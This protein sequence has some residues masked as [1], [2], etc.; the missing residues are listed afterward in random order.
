MKPALVDTSFLVAVYNKSDF[1]HSRCMRVHQTLEQPLATCEAVIAESIHLLRYAPGAAE[2]ILAS[3]EEGVLEIP[4]KLNEAAGKVQAILRK[5]RDTPAD[6]ADA[7]LIAMADE[8]DTGD[9]L[10]LDSDFAHYRWR[11]T[12]PFRMLIPLE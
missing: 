5:Y 4:F 11:R 10:T 9:I 6:F 12:R 3:I 2:A 7:C 8:L 1:H